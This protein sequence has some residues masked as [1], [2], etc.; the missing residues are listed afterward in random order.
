[1]I[2]GFRRVSI[3]RE[4]GAEEAESRVLEDE[5]DLALFSLALHENATTRDLNAVEIAIALEKL[6]NRFHVEP[7]EV[8]DRY[9]PLFSLET[10]E[11]ILKTYLDLA[12]MED[13]IKRY[14]VEEK[15]SRTNIRRL[16]SMSPEDRKAVLAVIA[17]LNLGENSLR[18]ILTLIEEISRREKQPLALLAG[19]PEIRSLLSQKDLTRS[20]RTDRVKKALMGLRY[21][22][23]HRLEEEFE[24]KR[25][26]LGLP[27]GVSLIHSPYFESK[28][29]KI[30][31]EFESLEEYG[32]IL[33]S[34]SALPSKR[35]FKA[36]AGEPDAG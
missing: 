9:L 29:L 25:K 21:P 4:L 1:V 26:A 16:A 30:Q 12:R 2:S 10:N 28:G 33:A 24:E 11:K 31:F 15:V 32:S 8:I 13:E 18:E 5:G 34:L 17:P 23:M 35:E 27:T 20:Q 22:R 7:S 36:L 3:L 6:V 14:V 19:H